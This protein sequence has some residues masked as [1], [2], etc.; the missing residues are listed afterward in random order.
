MARMTQT[1]TADAVLRIIASGIHDAWLCHRLGWAFKQGGIVSRWIY[2][3]L[4]G[5]P[6]E[7]AAGL[8]RLD[9]LYFT[10]LA[11][12][13]MTEIEL[14]ELVLRIQADLERDFERWEDEDLME[15]LDQQLPNAGVSDM[16]LITHKTVDA[17]EIV[18]EALGR[19]QPDPNLL[20]YRD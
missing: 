16:V 18:R 19:T 6:D 14:V 3:D 2:H 13:E 4:D 9:A 8:F 15:V 1:Q 17:R 20:V 11:A 12:P 5:D 7:I 10:R